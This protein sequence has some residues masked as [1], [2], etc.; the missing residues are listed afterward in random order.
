LR[1]R[2]VASTA[3]SLLRFCRLSGWRVSGFFFGPPQGRTGVSTQRSKLK[4]LSAPLLQL[5]LLF[6][7]VA[8][9]SLGFQPGFGENPPGAPFGCHGAQDT[10]PLP[11]RE[12]ALGFG[13]LA[14]FW[15]VRVTETDGEGFR[16]EPR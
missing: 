9:L 10:P 2:R 6:V 4:Q 13:E 14:G 3:V 12:G 8:G 5:P 11:S 1:R 7:E 16:R 15:P